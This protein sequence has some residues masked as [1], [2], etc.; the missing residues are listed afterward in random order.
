MGKTLPTSL[1]EV[2]KHRL[3]QETVYIHIC[4]NVYICI[5]F[6]FSNVQEKNKNRV[7]EIK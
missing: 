3:C 7:K 2:K 6:S 5:Y 4:T 1:K